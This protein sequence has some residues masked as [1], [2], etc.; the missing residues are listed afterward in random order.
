MSTVTTLV[1]F[2]ASCAGCGWWG[3][4]REWDDEAEADRAEHDKINHLEGE[5]K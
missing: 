3:E 1:Q 4:V 5:K 2:Q